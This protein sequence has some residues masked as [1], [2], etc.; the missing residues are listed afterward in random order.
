MVVLL[1]P[2][3]HGSLLSVGLLT[4]RPAW[5]I[6]EDLDS[7]INEAVMNILEQVFFWVHVF[8][9]LGQVTNRIYES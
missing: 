8:V 6:Q 9:S 3:L 5:A 7:K 2:K 1:L 4:L